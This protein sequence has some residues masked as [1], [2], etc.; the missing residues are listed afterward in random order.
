MNPAVSIVIPTYNQAHFL[1]EC[2]ET[3]R[4]QTV[5]DWECIVVNNFSDDDTVAVAL[6]FGDRRIRVENF[7]N[8]GVI[9][10][11]RNVGIRLAT[12]PWVA[13]LDSDDV[14]FPRKLERCLAAAGPDIDLVSHAEA[15]M[16]DG[17]QV[18]LKVAGDARSTSHRGLLFGNN[19][20]SPSGVLVRRDLLVELGGF[21]ED[22][23]LITAEDYDLWLRLAHRGIRIAFIDEA[24]AEYRLHGGNASGSVLR[25]MN[26]TLAVMERHAALIA[27]SP[28]DRLRLRAKRA[29]TRYAAGRSCQAAG[30]NGEA[31]VHFLASLT[32]WP[33][34]WKAWAAMAIA[35]L[36]MARYLY[37]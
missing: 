22:A 29:A 20:L 6:S 12:A 11:S 5:S 10:A 26:A 34:A 14:W 24:L 17:R 27:P 1:K 7:R 8:H 31:M 9:A 19:P 32:I 36:G 15:I 3:V 2:L 16:R 33:F 37:K 30:R 35:I 25:H 28:L 4:A 13:F 21:A 18:G 23:A